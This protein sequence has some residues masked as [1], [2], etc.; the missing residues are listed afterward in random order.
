VHNILITLPG[1]KEKLPLSAI[2]PGLAKKAR[3][4]ITEK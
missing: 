2:H 1:K 4:L 3:E